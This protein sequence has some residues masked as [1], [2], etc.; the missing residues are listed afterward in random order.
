VTAAATPFRPCVRRSSERLPAWM[1]GFGVAVFCRGLACGWPLGR[2][3]CVGLLWLVVAVSGAWAQN[4]AMSP[5]RLQPELTQ[6]EA[7]RTP[8]GVVLNCVVRLELPAVVEDALRKGTALVFV[9]E[10]R[11]WRARWYWWDKQL[12]QAS[13]S[14]RLTFHPLTGKYRVAFGGLGQSYDTLAEALA[15]MRRMADWRV[16]DAADLDGGQL[17]LEFVY[18]L[19]TSQLPRPLQIGALGKADWLLQVERIQSLPPAP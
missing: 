16:A 7:E 11:V 15:A 17:S 3:V 13:R 1:W 10:A 4:G 12:A 6:F 8:E 2:L 14:W 9:A 5:P 19:D 18:R